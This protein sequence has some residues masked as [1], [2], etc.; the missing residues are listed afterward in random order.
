[1]PSNPLPVVRRGT[2]LYDG[3]VAREVRILVSPQRYGTHDY[4]DVPEIADDRDQQTFVVEY[5]PLDLSEVRFGGGGQFDSLAE[6]MQS[7]EIVLD[8]RIRWHDAG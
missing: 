4:E 3:V 1:M 2:W 6:A 8:G 5:Q 7:A